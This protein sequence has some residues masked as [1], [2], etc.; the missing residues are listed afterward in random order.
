[1]SSILLNDLVAF[2]RHDFD[3]TDEESLRERNRLEVMWSSIDVDEARAKEIQSEVIAD[4]TPV[5]IPKRYRGRSGLNYPDSISNTAAAEAL[6]EK[7][8]GM[9]LATKWVIQW[10]NPYSMASRIKI[11]D[12]FLKRRKKATREAY[13]NF[14]K[15]EGRSYTPKAITEEMKRTPI[16]MG[17]RLSDLPPVFKFY[18]EA[19]EKYKVESWPT[20]KYREPVFPDR[21]QGLVKV[22]KQKF[23]V[24]KLLYGRS[25]KERMYGLVIDA[26]E[27]G[28]FS[29]LRRCTE[30][31]RFFAADDLRQKFC[32]ASC[33][34]KADRR[35]AKRRVRAMR[36]RQRHSLEIHSEPPSM[37]VPKSGPPDS[38]I[39]F[40]HLVSKANLPSG[41]E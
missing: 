28:D 15:S 31:H 35:D 40:F 9:N 30:C 36:K 37:A 4:L 39:K 14:L 12:K 10:V 2:L 34:D 6:V 5:V 18:V 33:R 7:I 17:G 22:G 20:E 3:A 24:S 19:L 1:M 16:P 21:G 25:P 38:F 32:I 26:L 41:Q 27:R 8:N 29:R 11:D 23:Y 13:A